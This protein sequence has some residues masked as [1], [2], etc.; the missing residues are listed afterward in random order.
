MKCAFYQNFERRKMKYDNGNT[1]PFKKE[2][3][4]IINI[5]YS[6]NQASCFICN[7]YDAYICG[8]YNGGCK[9]KETCKEIKIKLLEL[10]ENYNQ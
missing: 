6:E 10:I 8:Q 2:L 7:Y 5:G 1:T 4:K 3:R 9:N